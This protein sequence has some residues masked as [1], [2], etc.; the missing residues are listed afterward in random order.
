MRK[1]LAARHYPLQMYWEAVWVHVTPRISTKLRSVLLTT[2]RG[3]LHPPLALQDLQDAEHDTTT[4]SEDV[5]AYHQRRAHW[6]LLS[7][8][9]TS[10]LAS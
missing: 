10:T 9:R 2:V 7:Q 5:Q 3:I 4:T 6:M 1:V 8:L